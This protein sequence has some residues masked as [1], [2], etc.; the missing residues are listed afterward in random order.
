[1]GGQL[2]IRQLCSI[3]QFIPRPCLLFF[4]RIEGS[5]WR[6]HSVLL[7]AANLFINLPPVRGIA[8]SLPLGTMLRDAGWGYFLHCSINRSTKF[9]PGDQ[10][11]KNLR[12][13]SYPVR[14][15]P[16]QKW[17]DQR[18]KAVTGRLFNRSGNQTVLLYQSIN[19]IPTKSRKEPKLHI[20]YSPFNPRTKK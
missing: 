8:T 7:C 12:H 4:G 13:R 20:F 15:T 16:R 18:W 17:Q 11:D 2:K 9:K 6:L 3:D 19:Q 1:M 10:I 5:A 14:T